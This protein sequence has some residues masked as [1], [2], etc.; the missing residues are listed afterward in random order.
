MRSQPVPSGLADILQEMA[1]QN[2]DARASFDGATDVAKALAKTVRAQGKLILLGMG[3]SH[4]VNRI[5]ECAYRR[6]GVEAVSLPISEQLYSPLDLS[7]TP[8]LVTSQSG[9]SVEVH[10]LLESL[11]NLRHAFGL[12]LDAGSM[13]GRTVPALIGHGGTGWP[14]PP[15]AAF[16]SASRSISGFSPSWAT[17]QNRRCKASSIRTSWIFTPPHKRW[18]GARR[19]CSPAAFCAALRKLPHSG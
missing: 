11:P 9:E 3:G 13:L 5:A 8:V 7:G 1:R 4:A 16:S 2:A 15:R 19:S 12:T 17:I 6:L 10:R 14:M 18:P